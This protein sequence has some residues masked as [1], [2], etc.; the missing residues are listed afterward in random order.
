MADAEVTL[1]F[2]MPFD[3]V[4]FVEHDVLAYT[5][6]VT[7]GDIVGRVEFPGP[8]NPAKTRKISLTR[9]SS[10]PPAFDQFLEDKIWGLQTEGRKYAD[11]A[12][13]LLA[14]P[15]TIDL[16]VPLST[17]QIRGDSLRPILAEVS[18]WFDSFVKWLWVV[19]AQALDPRNPDPKVLHRRSNDVLVAASLRAEFSQPAEAR[20]DRP[21][22]LS[23]AKQS[24]ERVVSRQAIDFV[25]DRAATEPPPIMWEMLASARMAERR[26]DARRALID[27]G[28]ASEAALALLL[29]LTPNHQFTLGGLVA[30]A[31]R[32]LI[33]VPSDL[34]DALVRPRNDAVHRGTGTPGLVERALEIAEALVSKADPLFH[35]VTSF[36]M[37]NRPQLSN[38]QF[39]LPPQV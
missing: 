11:V 36:Q 21:I 22:R 29:G 13:V 33:D 12:A 20:P 10:A 8:P 14:F 17:I 35:P 4:L 30:E 6:D 7:L 31:E 28:T 26:E 34:R 19:T 24:A 39:I 16:Q 1:L 2:A 32:R 3:H 5:R 23:L 15:A 38:I 37:V 27:A 25:V 18:T 9:P